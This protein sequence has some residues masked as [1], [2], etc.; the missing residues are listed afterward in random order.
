[1]RFVMRQCGW[2]VSIHATRCRVAKHAER[3][4]DGAHYVVSIH[5][6]RCRVAKHLHVLPT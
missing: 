4:N 2:L 3:L 5:A 6:T 1:M